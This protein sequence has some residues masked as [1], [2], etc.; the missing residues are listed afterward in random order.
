IASSRSQIM[1]Y[2]E[3]WNI[4]QSSG[5]CSVAPQTPFIRFPRGSVCSTIPRR[6]IQRSLV[7]SSVVHRFAVGNDHPFERK[8]KQ[9]SQR[10]ED[11][12][13][14]PR[15]RPHPKLAFWRGERV[16]ENE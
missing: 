15:C 12:L 11:Q 8:L 7:R 3:H 1:G 16:C 9:R 13:I 10:G 2:W 6:E 14:V 5:L 4:I